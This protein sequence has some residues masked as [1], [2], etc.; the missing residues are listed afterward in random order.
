MIGHLSTLY[1]KKYVEKKEPLRIAFED[2]YLIYRH[3]GLIV[4]I[5][6]IL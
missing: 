1:Q 4:L 2:A 3:R 6:K 5:K